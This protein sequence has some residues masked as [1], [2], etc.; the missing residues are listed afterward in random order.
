MAFLKYANAVVVQPVT[1]VDGWSDATKSKTF[2]QRSASVLQKWDPD[3]HLLSHCTII[4]SV[5]TEVG[6]GPLG[7]HLEEGFQVD[8]KYPEY[9]IT[10][11]TSKYI[12]NNCFVPG[13]AITMAD[14]TVKSIEDV[15]EGDFVRSHLGKVRRVTQ[16][17]KR[18]IDEEILEIVP[19]GTTERLYVT[20]EHPFF[21][22]RPV[23]ECVHCGAGVGRNLKAISHLLGRH[24][25]SKECYYAH[26][27]PNSHYLSKKQ[28]EFVEAGRLTDRDFWATPVLADTKRTELSPGRARLLGLF[29]AEGYYE[30]DSRHGNEKVGAVWAFHSEERTTL[31]TTVLSLLKSEFGVEGVIRDHSSD[32]G[33]HVTTKTNRD[34]AAFFQKWVHGSCS[35][36]KYLDAALLEAEREVQLELVRGWLEGDGC[37]HVTDHDSRLSGTSSSRSLANQM[38]M[39]L[40]RLGVSSHL[41]RSVTEG[42]RRLVVDGVVRIVSDHSK[43]CVSWV[44][45]CGSGWLSELVEDTVYQKL[46]DPEVQNVPQLRFLNGYHLQKLSQPSTLQYEGYVYNFDVEADHSYIA[47]GVAVHNCDAWERKLLLATYKTFVGGYNFIEHIQ[48][49]EQSRGRILDA[50]PRDIGDSVYVDILVATERKHRPLIAAIESQQLNT[51]SMGC[52]VAHTTCSKCGNVAEDETQ[53]CKHIKY[54]KGNTFIDGL[55]KV[56]KIAELCGHFSDPKSVKF[57][58]ASWVANPAFKGAVVRNILSPDER[59]L[60]GAKTNAVLSMPAPEVDL[61]L[62]GRAARKLGPTHYRTVLSEDESPF[63]GEEFPGAPKAEPK[64]EE[65]PIQ[66]AV[67]DIADTIK[68][69]A[70]EKVRGDIAKGETPQPRADLS[71]NKNEN[72]IHQASQDPYWKSIGRFVLSKIQDPEVGRPLLLG[73]VLF[74]NG[75]W[76]AVREANSFSGRQVLEISRLLDE[77][78]GVRI[79]GETRIYKAVLD[80]G[81]VS[82]YGDI[83]SYL[84]ACKRV[85]GRDLTVSERDA[86]VVKGRLYDLGNS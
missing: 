18:R 55:G 84:T 60:L 31:A 40:H 52:T 7:Q 70:L 25:C 64:E 5:D 69:K 85:F 6:P 39:I 78:N 33:I 21:V 46:H 9:F 73:L 23:S 17:F 63:G 72:L 13:T 35:K 24:Y 48:I 80:V 20:K 66:K 49:P 57:I 44:V 59:R 14:G 68:E 76:N 1:S 65:D 19:R 36:K 61:S 38:Q 11:N 67:S 27:V 54:M 15:Q 82:P 71:E 79:A 51:L 53:M 58:E 10:A 2:D 45:S 43:E 30:L 16:T 75:G 50:V 56:R 32:S 22:F 37:Y 29:V 77:L 83:D 41:T 4:A 62:M 86:L 74:K 81:G 34:L 47:N 12:N 3:Q 28:G 8:R 26:R 42:R